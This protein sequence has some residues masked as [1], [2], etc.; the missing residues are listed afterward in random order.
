MKH[1]YKVVPTERLKQLRKNLPKYGWV[2]RDA[3]LASGYSWYY[4][5]NPHLLKK[6]KAYNMVM[7]D[8]LKSMRDER[9]RL[10]GEMSVRD[11]SKEEYKVMVDAIDKLSKNINLL[12]GKPTKIV[13]GNLRDWSTEDLK[14]MAYGEDKQDEDKADEDSQSGQSGQKDTDAPGVSTPA[15]GVKE[16]DEVQADKPGSI[17]VGSKG[18]IGRA[19]V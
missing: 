10:L 16:A 4:S 12:E 18:K 2:M 17:G 1:K 14:Q 15:G 19:H 7:K 3:M 11:L 8:T 5:C 9:T 6:T 13:E